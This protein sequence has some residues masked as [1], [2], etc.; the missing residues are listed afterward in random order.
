[1]CSHTPTCPSATS[2]DHSAAHVVAAHPEQG[3]S[4]LCNGVVLFEDY[5]E[6]LPDGRVC[7]AARLPARVNGRRD[8][9]TR[10]PDVGVGQLPANS[11]HCRGTS[12]ADTVLNP[13]RNLG[14][15]RIQERAATT[16]TVP[17]HLGRE[18]QR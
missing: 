7:A 1:M 11:G 2:Q 15:V 9:A 4:R 8:I 12:S 18:V 3:W 13:A 14:P 10:R 6:L 5:G 17:F 16:D